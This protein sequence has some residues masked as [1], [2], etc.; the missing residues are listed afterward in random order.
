MQNATVDVPDLLATNG[1]L[2]IISQVWQEKGV[3]GTFLWL[4]MVD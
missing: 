1:V 4:V 2:H 3:V